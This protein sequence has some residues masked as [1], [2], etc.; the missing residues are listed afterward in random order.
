MITIRAWNNDLLKVL[1]Q[2]LKD[3][4]RTSSFNMLSTA[5]QSISQIKFNQI[6]LQSTGNLCTKLFLYVIYAVDKNVSKTHNC[7]SLSGKS[8]WKLHKLNQILLFSIAET[9]KI[10][11]I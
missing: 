1:I 9:I 2:K 10:N 7:H 11:Q 3:Y 4:L 6:L 5:E 8:V